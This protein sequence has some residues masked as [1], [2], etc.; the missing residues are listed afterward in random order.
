M[1]STSSDPALQPDLRPVPRPV[2]RPGTQPP[3]LLVFAGLPGSGKT[4]VSR[5]VAMRLRAAYVRVDAIEAA[6]WRAGV[7][8]DQPTGLAA[9]VVGNTV[10]A[11]ALEAGTPAVVDAVNAVSAARD[12]WAATAAQAGA[13]LRFVE[14][15]CT[16]PV[17]HRRRV[18]ERFADGPDSP[19][20]PVPT[21]E[22][23]VARE[24]EPWNGPRLLLDST[25]TPDVLVEAVLADLSAR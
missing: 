15:V 4:T 24:W 19:G 14:V 16:D 12:G 10:A 3:A 5:A 20:L 8:R 18:T 9:Y 17:E 22:E 21:W 23:V 11:A 13:V 25:L 2:G 7:H 6:L 1:T